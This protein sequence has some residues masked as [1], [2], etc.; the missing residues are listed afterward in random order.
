MTREKDERPAARCRAGQTGWA[1]SARRPSTAS[2]R[3]AVTASKNLVESSNTRRPL[4][5]E[6]IKISCTVVGF[7]RHYAAGWGRNAR[8]TLNGRLHTA[9]MLKDGD[10]KKVESNTPSRKGRAQA[11]AVA[12]PTR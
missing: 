3:A 5:V 6:E 8:K 10:T 12:N 9:D 1:I 2:P 4:A 11:S 7:D